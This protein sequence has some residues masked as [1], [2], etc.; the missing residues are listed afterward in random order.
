MDTLRVIAESD[1]ER[2][3]FYVFYDK[4][5]FVQGKKLPPFLMNADCKITLYKNCRN[6]LKI[7]TTSL[8]PITERNPVVYEG[9]VEG[10]NAKIFYCDSSEDEIKAVDF[11][12][13]TLKAEGISDAV[14]LTCKTED[15]SIFSKELQNGLYKRKT[16]FTT[17]RKFKGLEADAVILTDVDKDTFSTDLGRQL[18]YVGASR[19]RFRLII[20][21]NLSDDDCKKVLEADFHVDRKIKRP[22]AELT[23]KLNAVVMKLD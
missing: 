7:A 2:R 11:A 8:R 17:C 19:A 16:R 13:S 21:A 15:K 10:D 12:V 6:T 9:A 14:I 4:M 22:K 20:V 18:F 3:S 5:Q 1:K 23:S